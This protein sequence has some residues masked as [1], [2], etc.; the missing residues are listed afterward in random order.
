MEKTI[1]T[2]LGADSM[3]GRAAGGI[4]LL[5][6]LLPA[7]LLPVTGGLHAQDGDRLFPQKPGMVSYTFRKYFEKDIPSTLDTIRGYGITDIEFSNLFGKTAEE[8]RSMIDAKGIHCSSFGVSYDD[9]TNKTDEVARNAK[10][11]GAAYVRVAGIPHQGIF[12]LANAQKA[13]EDFNRIGKLLKE[14]YGLGFIYHNHGFEFEPYQGGTLYDYIMTKTDP[15]YVSFEL[16]ILWAFFPGQ[17]PAGLLNKYGN[18]YKCLHLKDLRKGVQGNFSGGT[19]GDND[20]ALGTGQID[21]PGVMRAARKAG[22][23]HYYIED[24]SNNVLV[25]V[26]LSLAYLASLKK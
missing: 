17:D 1:R 6:V 22:V 26:P 14:Q 21:I 16:D 5:A 12:T 13:V 11:L 8:L 2:R 23:E 20:V 15:G 18:R 7:V 10:T 4:L 3:M 25:Q 19:A 9:A 24:E